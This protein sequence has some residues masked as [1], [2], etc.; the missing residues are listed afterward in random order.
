MASLRH[1]FSFSCSVVLWLCINCWC[2]LPPSLYRPE[3]ARH[4]YQFW[5][6]SS[7][8]YL[9]NTTRFRKYLAGR[10]SYIK[11]LRYELR[12]I[13]GPTPIRPFFKAFTSNCVIWSKARCLSSWIF[14]GWQKYELP[15]LCL[16]YQ[17]R[18]CHVKLQVSRNYLYSQQFLNP[19]RLC[20][21]RFQQLQNKSNFFHELI[22]NHI[23]SFWPI[24]FHWSLLITLENIKKPRIFW[25]FQG[26]SKEISGMKWVK[27]LLDI[28]NELTGTI[29]IFIKFIWFKDNSFSTN[30]YHHV[31]L[32]EGLRTLE[33][34]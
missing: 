4:L 8:F 16:L 15:Y 29:N 28:K 14:W 24:S 12:C 32:V 31:S 11:E 22:T 7:S 34:V 27:K 9:D 3:K 20:N 2:P 30:V 5:S 19:H 18:K 10:N 1:C 25:C 6:F 23:S 13:I 26:V 33:Y 17:H 21:L